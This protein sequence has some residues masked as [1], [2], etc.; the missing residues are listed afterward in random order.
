MNSRFLGTTLLFIVYR[1][2]TRKFKATAMCACPASHIEPQ[3]SDLEVADSSADLHRQENSPEESLNDNTVNFDTQQPAET[4]VEDTA[5]ASGEGS[6]LS[7]RALKRVNFASSIFNSF[8]YHIKI[9]NILF[10]N[11]WLYRQAV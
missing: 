4:S 6:T 2:C 11:T 3:T 7:K 10:T 1:T 5:V 8:C 9:V